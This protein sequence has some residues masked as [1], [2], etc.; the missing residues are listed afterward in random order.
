MPDAEFLLLGDAL[1]LEF[2][3]TARLPQ[4]TLPDAAA[5]LRWSKAVQVDNVRGAE[6]FSQVR[7]F[8][9]QLLVLAE[10]LHGQRHP[11]PSIIESINARLAGVEG[12]ERL[13]RVGG[14]WRIRFAPGRSPNALEAIAQSVASTLATPLAF[15]RLCANPGCNLFLLD[16]SS[17]QSRRWCSRS[18]CGQGTRVERRRNTRLTPVVADE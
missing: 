17:N 1:W 12:R 6:A 3:N 16:E 5:F 2:I 11:P 4:D 13:V 8:R 7:K 18:R 15:I 9:D 14:S 10:A